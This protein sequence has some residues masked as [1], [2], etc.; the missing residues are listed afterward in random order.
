MRDSRMK[1]VYLIPGPLV[2]ALACAL[3]VSADRI[4]P[5][6]LPMVGVMVVATVSAFISGLLVG[7]HLERWKRT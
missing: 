1:W 6:P 5:S 7:R 3:S 4:E 2:A